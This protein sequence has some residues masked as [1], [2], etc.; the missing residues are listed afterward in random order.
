MSAAHIRLTATLLHIIKLQ[1]RANVFFCFQYFVN[2][3]HQHHEVF[4][5]FSVLTEKR[6][7]GCRRA[8]NGRV[9]WCRM[10]WHNFLV[11]KLTSDPPVARRLTPGPK[12]ML[13]SLCVPGATG[14]CL[15]LS[16]L[17]C[18][19][20]T[21]GP[22]PTV[23]GEQLLISRIGLSRVTIG[24]D[25]QNPYFHSISPSCWL[26]PCHITAKSWDSRLEHGR[27]NLHW[28]LFVPVQ[29]LWVGFGI[30]IQLY[31][32]L[33]SFKWILNIFN[34]STKPLLDFLWFL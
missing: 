28:K 21:Q 17:Q 6:D 8:M 14:S 16:G 24:C 9:G 20:T 2:H 25:V 13:S 27:V 31:P 29:T 5:A 22:R 19:D 18:G 12:L 1:Q 3:C 26:S 11:W 23:T 34:R 30:I 15:P 10:L 7:A 4:M 33:N 32:M